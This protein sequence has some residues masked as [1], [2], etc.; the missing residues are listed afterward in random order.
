M[1]PDDVLKDI[2]RQYDAGGDIVLT[3]EQAEVMLS[4]PKLMAKAINDGIDA[5]MADLRRIESGKE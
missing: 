1:K 4:L 3:R 2:K 5:L